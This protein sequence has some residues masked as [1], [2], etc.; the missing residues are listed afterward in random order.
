MREPIRF[1]DQ[2]GTEWLLVASRPGEMRT[3]TDTAV[4][5]SAAGLHPLELRGLLHEACAT[6]SGFTHDIREYLARCRKPAA[7]EPEPE[8]AGYPLSIGT[9]L[10]QSE[11]RYPLPPTEP[12]KQRE[13]ADPYAGEWHEPPLTERDFP[14]HERHCCSKHGC[15][16]GHEDCPVVNRKRKQQHPCESCLDEGGSEARVKELEARR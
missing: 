9:E 15:K 16:Y 1:K 11:T 5:L 12:E 8:V 3:A 13:A 7:P 4:A 2:D 14:P 6:R 10:M